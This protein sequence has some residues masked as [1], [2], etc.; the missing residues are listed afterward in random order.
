MSKLKLYRFKEKS[1]HGIFLADDE[2]MEMAREKRLR[3]RFGKEH[4]DISCV[5][6][7]GN[8]C[9]VTEDPEFVKLVVWYGMEQGINPLQYLT[10][11]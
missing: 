1:L 8:V 3:C 7:R 5:L 11:E 2:A 4:S 6:N 9:L 10:D